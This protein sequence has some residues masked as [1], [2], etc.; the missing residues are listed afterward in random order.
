M[1]GRSSRRSVLKQAM[2]LGLTAPSIAAL[3]AACGG[4]GDDEENNPAPQA[5]ESESEATSAGSDSATAE[6][7]EPASPTAQAPESTADSQAG[8]SA[9]GG[10]L[11]RVLYWQGPTNL[12]PHLVLGGKDYEAARVCFEPLADFDAAGELQPFLAAEVPTIDNGGIASDGKSVTWKLREG[13]TWHDG[14]PFTSADVKFTWE[15][16]TNP[17]TP[18]QTRAVFDPIDSID[19]P[20]DL[21]VVVNFKEPNPAWFEGFSGEGGLMLPQHIL[22][23][24]T[25]AKALDAPFNLMPTGTG[26]FKVSESVP[27]DTVIYERHEGY[28]D[29]G[30]PYF[31]RVELKGGGDATSAARAVLQTGEYD[32]AWNLQVEATV[33]NDLS[34]DG[35]VG[36]LI[37]SFG[38]ST[39]RLVI[40]FSD[41]N[42]EVE[43]QRSFY[44]VPH[45]FF[46]D[47]AARE[48]LALA[49]DRDTIATQLYGVAGKPTPNIT[50]APDRFVSTNTSYEFNLEKAAAVLDEAGWVLENGQRAK[51]GFQVSLLYQT[52]TNPVRQKTQEV[53]KQALESIGIRVELKAI[54]AAVFFSTDPGNPDT[55]IR[56]EADMQMLAGGTTPYP[57]LA[58]AFYYSR[59][60]ETDV[61]QKSNS[62][63]GLNLSRWL[64]DDFNDLWL[65]ATTEIDPDKQNELFI[66]MNDLVIQEVVVVPLVHRADVSAASNELTDFAVTPWAGDLWRIADWK[67]A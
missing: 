39:E 55:Y 22:K 12:N 26:P 25:G 38:S 67:R 45:P 41:P 47:P 13:V 66:A 64:N 63:A 20:D 52:S 50:V 34:G 62:W 36:Q 19:T 23:D 37:S 6:G 60:P 43:G 4:D 29:A 56:F 33:L 30:K 35:A 51:D 27:G 54:D 59:D 28:W 8:S 32:W 3:L 24:W 18:A 57:L 5:T 2:G 17:D 11:V 49:A 14:A 44:Q 15:Y 9:G 48:M 42:Q 31:D 10:G 53:I 1:V 40:N 16:V 46:S 58:M 21:T 65:A 7:I 61:A